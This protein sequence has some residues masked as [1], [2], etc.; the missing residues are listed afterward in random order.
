MVI[1]GAASPFIDMPFENIE[2]AVKSIFKN[3]GDEVIKT[4]L[5][6]LHAGRKY[7]EMNK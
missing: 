3:K 4:N 1:L 6:A 7:A 5:D 2:N